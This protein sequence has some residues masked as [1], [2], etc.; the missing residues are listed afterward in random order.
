M[1]GEIEGPLSSLPLTIVAFIVSLLVVHQQCRHLIRRIQDLR[2]KERTN[3]SLDVELKLADYHKT[4]IQE[5][6]KQRRSSTTFDAL[7]QELEDLK[8]M[9]SDV[10][11][12]V[13]NLQ[14]LVEKASARKDAE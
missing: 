14:L 6:L 10:K 13:A 2:P 5:G 8:R 1:L 7:E 12:Q 4:T 9:H 11:T 3:D